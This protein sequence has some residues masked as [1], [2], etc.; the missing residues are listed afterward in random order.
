[1]DCL[2]VRIRL[3]GLYVVASMRGGCRLREEAE[4]FGAM[5]G[6]LRGRGDWRGVWGRV[7]GFRMRRVG[8][9]RER[10]RGRGCRRRM[11]RLRLFM[12]IR[13]WR[14]RGWVVGGVG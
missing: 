14:E 4:V 12:L 11:W 1:M 2:G 3:G 6:S 13:V 8:G 9:V 7:I 5:R 10:G